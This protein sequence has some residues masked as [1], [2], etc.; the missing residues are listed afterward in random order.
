MSY[1]IQVETNLGYWQTMNQI[2]DSETQQYVS[3]RLAD[4]SR[5]NPGKRVRAIDG[6]GRLV[7]IRG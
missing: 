3:I 4:I 7:D 5:S 2:P 6:S 1:Q